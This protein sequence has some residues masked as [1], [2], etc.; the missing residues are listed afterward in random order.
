MVRDRIFISDD[1]DAT[2]TVSSHGGVVLTPD[3]SD[4]AS[5]DSEP[6]NTPSA[7]DTISNLSGGGAMLPRSARG[8]TSTTSSDSDSLLTPTGSAVSE[9]L[10]PSTFA[11]GPQHVSDDEDEGEGEIIFTPPDSSVNGAYEDWSY[12]HSSNNFTPTSTSVDGSSVATIRYDTISKS[13]PC[14]DC[15]RS[16]IIRNDLRQHMDSAVHAPK[17][18]HYP[19]I[20]SGINTEVRDREFKTMSALVQHIE[21]KACKMG[22]DAMKTLLDVVDKPMRNKFNASI[23]PLEKQ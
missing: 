20:G 4:Y 7:N 9:R 6:I 21:D 1:N 18:F 8:G 5:T 22:E 13:W 23:S 16:F 12:I 17:I 14:T 2:S 19:T 10:T 3:A 11:P 15:L